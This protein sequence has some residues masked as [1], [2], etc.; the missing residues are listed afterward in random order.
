MSRFFPLLFGFALC[1]APTVQAQRFVDPTRP[2]NV[3]DAPVGGKVTPSAAPQLQSVLI[4]PAR[5]VAVISGTTVV[6]GGKFGD[7]TVT[8]I[9]E[10]AVHL[11]F[12]DRSQVLHLVPE[13]IKRDRHAADE[14]SDKG[15]TR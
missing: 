7:A 6:Q 8:A 15:I 5:R 1:G 3:S 10:G 14:R 4:S 11:R 12:A 2:P 9:T 13:G